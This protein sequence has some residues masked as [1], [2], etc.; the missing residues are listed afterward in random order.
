MVVAIA[1]K[2]TDPARIQAA[3]QARQES[4]TARA[5][6][7][8]AAAAEGPSEEELKTEAEDRAQQCSNARAQMQKLV[9]SR[10]LYREDENGERVYLDEDEM[11]A[12]RARVENRITEYC[13]S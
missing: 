12:A 10:R 5:E 3:A 2:P 6:A 8:T 13:G 9:V 7:E 1:S 4:R 11:I